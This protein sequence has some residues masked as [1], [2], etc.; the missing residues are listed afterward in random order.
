MRPSK[1]GRAGWLAG[2]ASSYPTM[3]AYSLACYDDCS[4][5]ACI[6]P[7]AQHRPP[8]ST[9]LSSVYPFVPSSSRFAS[10]T[11]PQVRGTHPWPARQWMLDDRC[12]SQGVGYVSHD[13]IRQG[14]NRKT[15]QYSPGVPALRQ[16]ST[17]GEP[18]SSLQVIISVFR[19]PSAGMIVP[20]GTTQDWRQ[21]AVKLT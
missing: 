17:S 7:R 12:H 5:F 6:L 21:P 9:S 14:E 10:R 4:W 11:W 13:N 2:R 1:P 3:H 20:T 16:H 19:G 8:C 15:E 18:S